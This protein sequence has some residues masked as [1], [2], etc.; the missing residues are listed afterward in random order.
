MN[1]YLCVNYWTGGGDYD[2]Y[3]FVDKFMSEHP[4]AGGIGINWLMFGSNGHIKKPKG[5]VLENYIRCAE[6]DL[7]TNLHIKTICDPLKVLLYCNPHFPIY[8]KG[9][10]NFDEAGNIIEGPFTR[11]VHFDKIRINHYYTKSKE[12]YATIK[13]VRGMADSNPNVRTMDYFYGGD[14]NEVLDT[15]ILSRI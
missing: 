4:K 8:R 6:K 13:M 7:T 15:E 2:L 11:E 14:R 5:G 12:E 3:N 10:H 1:L 9:F